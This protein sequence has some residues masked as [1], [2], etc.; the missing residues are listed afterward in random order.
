MQGGLSHKRNVR[1]SVR[2]SNARI[3]TKRKKLVPRFLYRM[4]DQLS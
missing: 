1:L 4:K 3:V 2:L